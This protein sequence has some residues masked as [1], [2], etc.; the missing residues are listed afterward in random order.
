MFT[1]TLIVPSNYTSPLTNM[2]L[3]SEVDISGGRTQL[4]HQ[5]K[6]KY[7]LWYL[8]SPMALEILILNLNFLIQQYITRINIVNHPSTTYYL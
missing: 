8:S 7:V 2:P 6:E 5:S 1:T 3:S 4:T